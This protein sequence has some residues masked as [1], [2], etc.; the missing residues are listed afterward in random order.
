MTVKNNN[1]D[2]AS[3][4]TNQNQI[5]NHIIRSYWIYLAYLLLQIILTPYSGFLIFTY[6]YYTVELSSFPH[7]WIPSILF[8]L[9]AILFMLLRFPRWRADYFF[10]KLTQEKISQFKKR[11]SI[12]EYIT[13]IPSYI[14]ILSLRI[15]EWHLHESKSLDQ[16]KKD[17]NISIKFSRIGIIGAG[18]FYNLL[19]LML[20]F[21]IEISP[22][23]LASLK[24][25]SLTLVN[26]FV[27]LFFLMLCL[28]WIWLNLSKKWTYAS[29]THIEWGSIISRDENERVQHDNKKT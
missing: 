15:S 27:F 8:I 2:L 24:P 12:S 4:L 17:I 6:F 28:R 14:K 22:L 21:V 20:R 1:N 29:Q 3:I 23:G 10:L 16:N 19:L 11:A 7:P 5:V 9:I 25:I 18:V 26:V 13:G